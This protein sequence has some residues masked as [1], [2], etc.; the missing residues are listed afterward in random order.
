MHE[1]SDADP[2]K[3]ELSVT[4]LQKLSRRDHG[5]GFPCRKKQIHQRASAQIFKGEAS[6]SA[7][8]E[9]AQPVHLSASAY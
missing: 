2:A 6:P 4:L 9:A 8:E 3:V 1:T 7:S 5:R